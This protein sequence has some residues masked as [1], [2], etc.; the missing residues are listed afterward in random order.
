MYNP[1][2]ATLPHALFQS[3]SILLNNKDLN[4][5]IPEWQKTTCLWIHTDANI[6]DTLL[7]VRFLYSK[8][9]LQD[10]KCNYFF[11]FF[12]LQNLFL[13]LIN[14]IHDRY[15]ICLHFESLICLFI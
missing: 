10:L 15:F 1:G 6:K 7:C 13:L 14:S 4:L 5:C 8:L 9:H 2:E 11:L 3:V 12:V